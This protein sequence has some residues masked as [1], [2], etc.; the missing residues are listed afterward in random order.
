M[1][2]DGKR[3]TD[4]TKPVV[5]KITPHDIATGDNKNQSSCPAAKA[6]KHSIE[7][8]ISARVYNCRIYIEQDKEWIRYNPSDSLK[9]KV[10]AFDRGRAFAPGEYTLHPISLRPTLRR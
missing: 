6:A 3:V 4:A 7:N 5:I 1:E 10:I 8:C 2:I 9:Q